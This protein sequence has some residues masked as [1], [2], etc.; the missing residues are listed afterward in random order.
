[1][2]TRN[3]ALAR[4]VRMLRDWG[5]SERYA[6]VLKGF[7]Y[8]MEALQARSSG[9][10]SAISRTGREARRA[11]AADYGAVCADAACS[12][13]R[14]MPY[15]H[16]V[17]HVYAIRRRRR[18]DWQEALRASGVQTGVHYPIPVHLLPAYANLGHVPGD[19]P[20]AE[21]AAREVLSLPMYPELS[22][23]FRTRVVEAVHDV[24]RASRTS[25]VA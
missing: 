6:H 11:H 18:D 8:R 24:A 7:N 14:S 5:R 2:A 23:E 15:A 1:M 19:F 10:S 25:H 22:E 4:T 13:P 3:P 17:Y 9:S 16:H 12:C 21:R 20:H